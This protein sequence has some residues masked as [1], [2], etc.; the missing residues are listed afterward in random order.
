MDKKELRKL[1]GRLLHDENLIRNFRL[2]TSMKGI[3]L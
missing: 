1:V 2:H 3:F